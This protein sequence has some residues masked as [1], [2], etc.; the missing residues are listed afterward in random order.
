MILILNRFTLR[1]NI[2][3]NPDPPLFYVHTNAGPMPVHRAPPA[4]AADRERFVRDPR[5]L[6]YAR[7]LTNAECA[8]LGYPPGSSLSGTRVSGDYVYWIVWLPETSSGNF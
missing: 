2:M 1:E 8:E 5:L 3:L 6:K 4:L 7:Q